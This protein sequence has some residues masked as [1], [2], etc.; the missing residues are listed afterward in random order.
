MNM[1]NPKLLKLWKSNE[2]QFL[3]DVCRILLV[4]IAVLIF[5]ELVNEI[6]SVKILSNDP[7]RVCENKTGAKCFYNNYLFFEN[8]FNTNDI[9]SSINK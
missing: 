1:L 6:E 3:I 5:L 2:F 8:D 9:L 7:C 4:V